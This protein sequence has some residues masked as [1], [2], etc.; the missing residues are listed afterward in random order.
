MYSPKR[1]SPLPATRERPGLA[2]QQAK[3]VGIPSNR[4]AEVLHPLLPSA[5]SRCRDRPVRSG[6]HRDCCGPSAAAQPYAARITSLRRIR[7]RLWTTPS[8]PD[9]STRRSGPGPGFTRGGVGR[10]VGDMRHPLGLPSGADP[11]L[12]EAPGRWPHDTLLRLKP[13]RP[14]PEAGPALRRRSA[15]LRSGLA[16]D[17]RFLRTA[18]LR[19]KAHSGQP[20]P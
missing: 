20:Y 3:P 19:R 2:R 18:Q 4:E 10:R 17:A 7:R 12:A 15:R 6:G 14:T 9:R 16:P 13:R 11:R 5:A 8:I 1:G